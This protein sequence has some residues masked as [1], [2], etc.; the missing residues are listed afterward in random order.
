MSYGRWTVAAVMLCG[1]ARPAC[2]QQVILHARTMAAFRPAYLLE[3]PEVIR[4]L[5]LDRARA[6]YARLQAMGAA[7]RVMVELENQY[8]DPTTVAANLPAIVWALR[9]AIVKSLGEN[10]TDRQLARLIQLE[11]QA[12]GAEAF[13]DPEVQKALELTDDQKKQVRTVLSDMDRQED[14][15][16]DHIL[17]N[18]KRPSTRVILTDMDRLPQSTVERCTALLTEAQRGKWR[19]LLGPRF[20]QESRVGY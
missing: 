19:E 20:F 8:K 15:L 18:S 16:F 3:R 12:M 14:A 4:E 6:V 13:A 2:G 5:R 1:L 9:G 17:M 11:R 7:D 10:L